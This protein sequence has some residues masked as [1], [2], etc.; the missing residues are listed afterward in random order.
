MNRLGYILHLE[1]LYLFNVGVKVLYRNNYNYRNKLSYNTELIK[2]IDK[3]TEIDT[4]FFF[5][6]EY[7]FK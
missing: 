1:H 4:V 7:C 3:T 2:N 5:E 6:I